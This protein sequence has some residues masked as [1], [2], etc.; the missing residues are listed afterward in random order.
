MGYTLCAIRAIT[1]DGS[2]PH[3]AL[4]ISAGRSGQRAAGGGQRA[5]GSGGGGGG[6][7]AGTQ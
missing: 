4:A 6:G 5:A 2:L 3:P 7:R 1:T